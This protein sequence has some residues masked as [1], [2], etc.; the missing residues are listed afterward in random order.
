MGLTHMLLLINA[1]GMII[2]ATLVIIRKHSYYAV[3]TLAINVLL[4]TIEYGILFDLGTLLRNLSTI[5]SLMMIM[6]DSWVRGDRSSA[7]IPKIDEYVVDK[8]MIFQLSGRVLLTCQLIHSSLFSGEGGEWGGM[9]KAITG[10]L[11][12]ISC[13]MVILGF[14]ARS[15][16]IVLLFMLAIFNFLINSFWTVSKAGIIL[17]FVCL[18]FSP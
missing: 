9:W 7:G 16:G 15:A 6:A 2:G 18:F 5:G 17:L 14:K 8:K 11:G 3:I 1:T 12:T 4:Q 13:V 10:V